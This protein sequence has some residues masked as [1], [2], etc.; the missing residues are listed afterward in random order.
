MFERFTDSARAA[1]IGARLEAVALGDDRIGT[2]HLLVAALADDTPVTQA[3]A[4]LGLTAE[5][6]RQ[7]LVDGRGAGF[8][9]DDD[10]LRELG[11]DIDEVRRRAEE[12]FGP[13]ALDRP[14][15]ERRSRRS[16]RRRECGPLGHGHLPFTPEAKKSLELALREALRLHSGEIAVD[17]IVL[18]LVRADGAATRL[19]T[20]LG[21]DPAAVRKAVLDLRRAA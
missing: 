16:R 20:A 18:G 17:H 14:V 11:I 13:G 8:T 10:A 15:P 19:V 21:A 12:R 1:V 9:A 7:R 2:E 6:V 5:R 3:L 4:R